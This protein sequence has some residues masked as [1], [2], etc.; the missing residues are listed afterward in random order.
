MW[1]IK[2]TNEF[3]GEPLDFDGLELVTSVEAVFDAISVAAYARRLRPDVIHVHSTN[4]SALLF[5][6]LLRLVGTPVVTTA[7]VVTPHERRPVRDAL[8]RRVHR[9]SRLV[10]A[11]SDFD[12]Q[13]LLEEISLEPERVVVIPHGEYGFFNPDGGPLARDSARQ[14]LGLDEDHEVV[15]FFGYIR[16]YKGLDLLLEAWPRVVDALPQARLVVAGDASRLADSRRQELEE[17]EERE[18]TLFE[19][20]GA[21]DGDHVP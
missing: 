6:A 17:Q 14:S 1:R 10:V 13:R 9:L 20:E 3:G 11:H 8:F 2:L 16:E 15:L 5:V 12:R 18:G 4:S 21:E 19:G 7:H